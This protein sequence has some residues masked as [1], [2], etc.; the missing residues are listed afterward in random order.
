MPTAAEGKPRECCLGLFIAD[1]IMITLFWAM[2]QVSH[3]IVE[4]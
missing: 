4:E 2:I 1:K 3:R